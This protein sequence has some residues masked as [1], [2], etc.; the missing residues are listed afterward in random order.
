MLFQ[1]MFLLR[2][3]FHRGA[4]TQP[5]Q[6]TRGQ[7]RLV[8]NDGDGACASMQVLQSLS[9][10]F[11]Y[12]EVPGT[13]LGIRRTKHSYLLGLFPIPP[14]ARHG[15]WPVWLLGSCQLRA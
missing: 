4:G 6:K 14:I 1:K 7:W 5:M 15:L 9:G 3:R 8:S 13:L 12:L 2:F 10:C 11:S